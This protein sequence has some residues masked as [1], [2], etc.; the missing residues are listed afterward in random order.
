MND[1]ESKPMPLASAVQVV[2]WRANST[3]GAMEPWP[4]ATIEIDIA[5]KVT[6]KGDASKAYETLLRATRKAASR[7]V[8]QS[9]REAMHEAQQL[10]ADSDL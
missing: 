2:K 10:K 3:T 5:G 6:F 9:I 1:L 8:D 7:L 4:V